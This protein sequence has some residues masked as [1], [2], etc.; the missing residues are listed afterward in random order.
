MKLYDKY[1][2]LKEDNDLKKYLFRSGNFYIF[3][4]D[5]ARKISN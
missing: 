1:K 3:I 5:D 2:L 4:D